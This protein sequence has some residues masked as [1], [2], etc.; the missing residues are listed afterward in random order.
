M[1]KDNTICPC[2]SI[3]PI[4]LFPP[5]PMV[6]LANGFST[7]LLVYSQDFSQNKTTMGFCLLGIRKELFATNQASLKVV[8]A[9]KD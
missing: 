5:S 3:G 9:P 4:T 6:F 8:D 1:L 2:L 7:F